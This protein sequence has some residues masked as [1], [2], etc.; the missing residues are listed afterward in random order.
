VRGVCFCLLQ[1]GR[2][3]QG[4]FGRLGNM[5]REVPR[6]DSEG[7]LLLPR[8]ELECCGGFRRP[9]GSMFGRTGLLSLLWW[10]GGGVHCSVDG[11]RYVDC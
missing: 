5:F 10:L 7:L 2:V 4:R 6:V 3:F 9:P 11:R 8:F 1:R